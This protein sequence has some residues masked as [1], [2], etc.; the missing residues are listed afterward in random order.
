MAGPR[1]GPAAPAR[2]DG[3]R[4]LE[5]REVDLAVPAADAVQDAAARAPQRSVWLTGLSGPVRPTVVIGDEAG[6]VRSSPISSPTR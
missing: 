1:R 2:L 6:C 3:E 4:P 5:R